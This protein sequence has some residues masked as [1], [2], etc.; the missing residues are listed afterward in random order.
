MSKNF[1]NV[2]S[3]I[4]RYDQVILTQRSRENDDYEIKFLK[5]NRMLHNAY[6][7][8]IL[9]RILFHINFY[10]ITFGKLHE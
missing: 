7:W 2:P 8:Y 1:Q 6:R 4:F 5:C 10:N 9:Q 3:L